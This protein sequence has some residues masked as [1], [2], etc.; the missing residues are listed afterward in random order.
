M[1]RKIVRRKHVPSR[2]VPRIVLGAAVVAVVPA[3]VLTA[4]SLG[5]LGVA[6]M[7][8][9]SAPGVANIGFEAGVANI[10]F[11]GGFSVADVGFRNQDGGDAATDADQD[12]T[13][14]AAAD[15][16]KD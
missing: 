4:C 9:D 8:F 6:E 7:A 13:G 3:L 15:A 2:I 10:G 16:K 1:S 12:A 14:D 11:D 5:G